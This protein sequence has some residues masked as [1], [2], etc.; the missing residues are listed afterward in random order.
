[1]PVRNFT[2]ESTARARA[3]IRVSW[4]IDGSGRIPITEHGHQLGGRKSI[5]NL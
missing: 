1:M 5:R 3:D 2:S 4:L